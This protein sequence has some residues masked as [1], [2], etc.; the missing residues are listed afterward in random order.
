MITRGMGLLAKVLCLPLTSAL[1]GG[2]A[3]AQLD[4]QNASSGRQNT[5]A[6]EIHPELYVAGAILLIGGTLILL[7]RRRRSRAN[8]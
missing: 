4:P 8:A 6:P 2:L 3:A 7:S 5:S 1:L